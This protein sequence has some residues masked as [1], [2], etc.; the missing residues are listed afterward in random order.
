MEQDSNLIRSRW[1]L[2][3]E[4]SHYCTGGRF[5]LVGL[6]LGKI[7]DKFSPLVTCI[8]PFGTESTKQSSYYLL[9]VDFVLTELDTSN[10]SGLGAAL[11]L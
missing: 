3:K 1:L 9:C 5:C 2:L 4:S 6:Y 10:F 8:A 11:I 7:V